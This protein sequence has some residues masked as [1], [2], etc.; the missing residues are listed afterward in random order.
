MGTRIKRDFTRFMAGTVRQPESALSNHSPCGFF[1]ETTTEFS[2]RICG[3]VTLSDRCVALFGYN[4]LS[5]YKDLEN[6]CTRNL[7]V[8]RVVNHLEFY[9]RVT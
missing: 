6:Y 3:R 1:W 4:G 9:L 5:N 7:K 2:R 8:I